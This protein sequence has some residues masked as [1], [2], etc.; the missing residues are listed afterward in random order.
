MEPRFGTYLPCWD[1]LDSH[2]QGGIR[3]SVRTSS[4]W[5]LGSMVMDR[6]D[7]VSVE[8]PGKLWKWM[9]TIQ[10]TETSELASSKTNS[11]LASVT[12]LV[13]ITCIWQTQRQAGEWKSFM[14]EK[15]KGSG[16]LWLET[17][18]KGKLLNIYYIDVQHCALNTGVKH[19]P[20][21]WGA[22]TL[23][24]EDRKLSTEMQFGKY[25]G[26]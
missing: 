20:R 10:I 15:G 24:E 2:K 7:R 11:E 4:R 3:V 26:W 22:H 21:Q 25:H 9:K 5:R 8:S 13:I 23:V 18:G 14:L 12:D 17:V 6:A 1:R 19:N 16:V